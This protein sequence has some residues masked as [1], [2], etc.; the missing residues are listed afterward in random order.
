[1]CV[2]PWGAGM[3]R[4][5]GHNGPN[6]ANTIQQQISDDQGW[7]TPGQF[8]RGDWGSAGESLI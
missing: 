6:T 3:I 4:G 1:M 5:R 2:S 8:L 7:A